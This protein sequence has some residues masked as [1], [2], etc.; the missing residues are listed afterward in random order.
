MLKCRTLRE[1]L[2]LGF[3]S[4]YMRLVLAHQRLELS[5]VLLFRLVD[6]TSTLCGLFTCVAG[7]LDYLVV[8]KMR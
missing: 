8:S 2:N 3:E 4:A 6:A 7:L 5:D 1:F